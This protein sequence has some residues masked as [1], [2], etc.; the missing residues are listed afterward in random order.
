MILSVW[1]ALDA[2][3]SGGEEWRIC[4]CHSHTLNVASASASGTAA[5]FVKFHAWLPRQCQVIETL[6]AER[7]DTGS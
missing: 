3:L 2:F 6:G 1:K 4:Y 5:Y 7:C